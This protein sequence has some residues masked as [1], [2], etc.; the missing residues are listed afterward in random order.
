VDVAK[1]SGGQWVAVHG[2]G[3]VG[4]SAIMIASALGANV[5]AIDITPE[6][7]DFARSVGAA[8]VV[9]ANEADVVEAV[10]EITRGGAHVSID[11]LGSPITSFNSIACLR[12]RGRHVQIGLMVA[13]QG[14][15]KIPMSKVISKELEIYGSHGM[16]AF[17]YPAL[18]EMIRSDKLHPEK[19]VGRT[20]NLEQAAL[21]LTRMES[22]G[23][24]GVTVINR[25]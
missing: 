15:A 23:G 18:F 9:N 5:I 12:K 20:I 14:Q 1:V 13:D 25:F 19:L 17:R 11:A 7:L 3:G 24:L 8:V 22:F 10:T 21:E 6:K 2:C 4:L 16:Q